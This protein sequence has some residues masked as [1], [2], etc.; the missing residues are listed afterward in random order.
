M[1]QIRRTLTILVG[2]ASGLS[3]AFFALIVESMYF[4]GVAEDAWVGIM[5]MAF[6][7]V[8]IWLV[9]NVHDGTPIKNLKVRWCAN[10]LFYTMI[11]MVMEAHSIDWICCFVG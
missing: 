5:I 4:D 11:L 2:T 8:V 10:T 6:N 7:F 1:E 3:F 9:N